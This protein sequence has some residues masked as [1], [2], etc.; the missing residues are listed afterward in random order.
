[1]KKTPDRV[2]QMENGDI[3]F[4]FDLE[5]DKI[6]LIAWSREL[7]K[8]YPEGNEPEITTHE[9]I[10]FYQEANN[11][12]LKEIPLKALLTADHAILREYVRDRIEI[13]K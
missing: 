1:M 12:T 8:F 7:E 4:F 5:G 13:P 6:G 2:Y 11:C 9:A 3:L 10:D